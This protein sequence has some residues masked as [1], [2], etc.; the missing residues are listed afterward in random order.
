MASRSG[1]LIKAKFEQALDRRLTPPEAL[2]CEELAANLYTGP[3]LTYLERAARKAVQH[4][5]EFLHAG[6]RNT[7]RRGGVL[8]HSSYREFTHREVAVL[9]RL[10]AY[11]PEMTDG[12][13]EAVVAL[14]AKY[15]DDE[16]KRAIEAAKARGVRHV[17]YVL[18]VCEGAAGKPKPRKK[19]A[20][21]PVAVAVERPAPAAVASSWRDALVD[22]DEQRA[23]REA[24]RAASH[25]I[26]DRR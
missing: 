11:K 2:R 7:L 22:A 13:V 19:A 25:G 1:G 15:D 17:R 9:Q 5:F 10:D 12:E 21:R 20:I 3:V 24:E 6:A 8:R 14:A 26:Q 23:V 16:I 4:T 18:G